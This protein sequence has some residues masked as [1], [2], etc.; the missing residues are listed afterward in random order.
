MLKIVCKSPIKCLIIL[1]LLIPVISST[2]IN[3]SLPDVSAEISSLQQFCGCN[4]YDSALKLLHIVRNC[5]TL[6]EI[7][8]FLS[9]PHLPLLATTRVFLPLLIMRYEL[10]ILFTISFIA[11][12]YKRNEHIY[13]GI[14][15]TRFKFFFG[16]LIKLTFSAIVLLSIQGFFISTNF[17]CALELLFS[18][19]LG[20]RLAVY[21]GYTTL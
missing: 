2:P 4:C 16:I 18:V 12:R 8:S 1:I 11:W 19:C 3:Y 5:N 10:L 17:I 6:R 20:A 9:A 13:K 15:L 7:C 14:D 21:G